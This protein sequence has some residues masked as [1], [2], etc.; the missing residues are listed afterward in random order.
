[1][2]LLYAASAWDMGQKM[3]EFPETLTSLLKSLS[4]LGIVSLGISTCWNIFIAPEIIMSQNGYYP[5]FEY[6]QLPVQSCLNFYGGI[7]F[8]FRNIGFLFFPYFPDMSGIIGG[9]VLLLFGGNLFFMEYRNRRKPFLTVIFLLIIATGILLGNLMSARH[10]LLLLGNVL[11][12][13]YFLPLLAIL[14]GFA[15][16]ILGK[17]PARRNL[18][19]ILLCISAISGG[20]AIKSRLIQPFSNSIDLEFFY[21][22]TAPKVIYYLNHPESKKEMPLQLSN[23]YMIDFFRKLQQH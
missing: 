5:S 4:F 16:V 22:A 21:K 17:F 12:G 9:A 6:Q 13:I 10:N 23:S 14:A 3:L 18:L 20:I 2:I 1:M 11:F 19:L 15:A 8:F 7:T